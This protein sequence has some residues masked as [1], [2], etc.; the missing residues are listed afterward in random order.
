MGRSWLQLTVNSVKAS[1][2]NPTCNFGPFI[3]DSV[4]GVVVRRHASL[5][6]SCLGRTAFSAR[7]LAGN[8]DKPHIP[9]C[10]YVFVAESVGW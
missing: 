3:S 7:E 5:Q 1:V 10:R 6:D 4:R 2:A 9:L 8:T